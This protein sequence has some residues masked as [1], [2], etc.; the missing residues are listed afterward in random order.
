MLQYLA[1]GVVNGQV[2]GINPDALGH[3]ERIVAYLSGRLN[4]KSMQ[5]LTDNKIHH[6]IKFLIKN[7]EIAVG[8][9]SQPG[10]VDGSK[11]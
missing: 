4:L 6:I 5:Q 2:L 10:K 8:F 3:Q 1:Y 11:T 9:N 7:F